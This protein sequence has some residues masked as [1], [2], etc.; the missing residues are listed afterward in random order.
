MSTHRVHL[1]PRL[2]QDV[3]LA[4][5]V[6]GVLLPQRGNRPELVYVAVESHVLLPV[7]DLFFHNPHPL[8]PIVEVTLAYK[9][10]YEILCGETAARSGLSPTAPRRPPPARSINLKLKF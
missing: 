2:L 8:C 6:L 4:I 5:E 10:V 9:L 3:L 7:V 1:G